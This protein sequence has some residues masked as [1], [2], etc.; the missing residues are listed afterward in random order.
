LNR[1]SLTTFTTGVES[2][3]DITTLEFVE[4]ALNTIDTIFYHDLC[5][6]TLEEYDELEY[7]SDIYAM[8]SHDLRISLTKRVLPNLDPNDIADFEYL[9]NNCYILEEIEAFN[10]LLDNPNVSLE[11]K[12]ESKKQ[13]ENSLEDILKE[14]IDKLP[15][16]FSKLRGT[17]E[18]LLEIISEVLAVIR[19]TKF[20]ILVDDFEAY[21]DLGPAQW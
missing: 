8:A 6:L 18:G 19:G 14:L 20:A 16:P 21:N 3:A 17:L 7:Y 10:R 12:T 9:I 1:E 15:G 13:M 5:Q 2:E 4:L 11:T